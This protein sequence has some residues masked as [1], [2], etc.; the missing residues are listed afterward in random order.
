MACFLSDAQLQDELARREAV[1]NRR[2]APVATLT[3][4]KPATVTKKAA[5][6]SGL[7]STNGNYSDE[8]AR[9]AMDLMS[10]SKR[11]K[12]VGADVAFKR[13]AGGIPLGTLKRWRNVLKD[14]RGVALKKAIDKLISTK[15][16]NPNIVKNKYLT[17][18]EKRAFAEYLKARKKVG[19]GLN[20]KD[21]KGTKGATHLSSPNTPHEPHL[22]ST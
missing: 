15:A 6:E 10:T 5:K 7:A 8:M 16:G 21:A 4:P 13:V 9:K 19:R 22:S 3:A 11:Q 14:L 1:R 18:S 12:G 17:E 2:Q 20:R